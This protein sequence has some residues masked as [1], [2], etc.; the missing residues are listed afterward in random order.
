VNVLTL[1]LSCAK[2]PPAPAAAR[3]A[4]LPD[5]RD[6]MET[7]F[8]R[9]LQ[10]QLA[11]L[12]GELAHATDA[13]TALRAE[14]ET[15]TYPESWQPFVD[16]SKGAAHRAAVAT[17]IPEAAAAL[18]DLSDA[19]A[20]CHV[21]TGGGPHAPVRDPLPDQHMARHLYGAYWAGYGVVAPDDRSWSDGMRALASAPV[22]ADAPKLRHLDAKLHE[23]AAR[24]ATM[25]DGHERA[26]LWGE[27]LVVCSECHATLERR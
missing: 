18:G 6:E 21:A 5:L 11:V 4:D 17:T 22:G 16:L 19:C 7:H 10:L 26:Q 14:L 13:A 23:L 8:Y 9:A 25:R 12:G 1:L 27:L 2:A 20:Q 15:G 24:G 3:P